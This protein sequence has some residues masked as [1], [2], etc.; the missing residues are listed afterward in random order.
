MP[1]RKKGLP[2]SG[3]ILIDKP[4]GMSSNAVVQKVK[5]LFNAQKAGHTGALD[6]L[7]TGLLPICLGEATKFSQYS[8]DADKAYTTIAKLGQRT[9]TSDADGEVVETRAVEITKAQVLV[10]LEQ[11][12]GRQKQTP[13]VY[14]AL[15]YQGKPLY[16]YARKGID[17][18]RPTRDINIQRLV[19]NTFIGDELSLDVTCS[20]GTYIRTLVDDL[21]Q[22]LRCGAHVK[23]LRRE[24]ITGFKGQVLHSLKDLENLKEASGLDALLKLL[25]PID[26]HLSH[27][28]H[29]F[30]DDK[31]VKAFTHG[32]PISIL[33]QAVELASELRVYR[34]SD[35]KML[36]LAVVNEQHQL[37]PKRLVQLSEIS[38]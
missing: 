22:L 37:Q 6:P 33:E 14:S 1:R 5:W 17:V 26:I 9:D 3:I 2:I 27:M 20:K 31:Q 10:A 34:K 16:Y 36:G 23:E 19:L 24:W 25:L 32:N 8:L 35:S 13:S 38:S 7:A 29:V 21:G 15:K 28:Q 30:I 11:F 12:K 18:P 4:R